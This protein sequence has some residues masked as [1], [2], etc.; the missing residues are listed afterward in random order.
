MSE[1][2]VAVVLV[3][4]TL[5]TVCVAWIVA[6]AACWWA[7]REMQSQMDALAIRQHCTRAALRRANSEL[8]TAQAWLGQVIASHNVL[9]T[10]TTSHVQQLEANQS[11][12]WD[13]AED[14]RKGI[15]PDGSHVDEET[16]E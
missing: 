9:V 6:R 5:Y 12:S 2:V 13:S 7:C 3:W 11:A 4:L 8:E 16:T 15:R 14:W 1:A 10:Y